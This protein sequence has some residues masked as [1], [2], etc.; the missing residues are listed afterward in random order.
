M[1]FFI[2]L[3]LN[4][5]VGFCYF[6]WSPGFPIFL[7]KVKPKNWLWVVFLLFQYTWAISLYST[8]PLA[9]RWEPREP[10]GPCLSQGPKPVS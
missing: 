5:P 4:S 10:L 7:K 8:Q 6:L 9:L 2:E 3:G 1:G